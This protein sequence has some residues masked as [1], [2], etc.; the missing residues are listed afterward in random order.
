MSDLWNYDRITRLLIEAG[1]IARD[2][3]QNL[4]KSLKPDESLVTAA[5]CAIEDLIVAELEDEAAGVYLIGEET[6]AGRGEAYLEKALTGT[7][8]VVDPIDGTVPYAY[9]LP[10][11]GISIALLEDGQ[12]TQGA[13][14]LPDQPAPEIYVSDG[15]RVRLAEQTAGEWEWSELTPGVDTSAPLA[16]SQ[17]IARAGRVLEEIPVHAVGSAV[18]ELI[19]LLRGRY[20][21]YVG[22]LKLWDLAGCM[23]LLER[24]GVATYHLEDG[25]LRPFGASVDAS[26]FELE[27][28]SERR[29]RLR[30][31]LLAALAEDAEA[32]RALIELP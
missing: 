28:G 6:L 17:D 10:Y 14:H 4:R 24:M 11:W 21:T 3:R 31:W 30:G 32:V 20:R 22:S 5:D 9:G 13:I 29:W 2:Y 15:D 19:G 12:L 18:Y 25:A 27:A 26:H 1:G 7:T 8:F 23:P 16:I